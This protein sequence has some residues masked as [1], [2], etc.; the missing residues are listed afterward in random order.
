M[1]CPPSSATKT[2]PCVSSSI[3]VVKQARKTNIGGD[4]DIGIDPPRHWWCPRKKSD[5]D[6]HGALSNSSGANPPQ[7]RHSCTCSDRNDTMSLGHDNVPATIHEGLGSQNPRRYA[8][9]RS[10]SL[11]LS[12]TPALGTEF[13]G[14]DS[15]PTILRE[16]QHRAWRVSRRSPESKVSDGVIALPYRKEEEVDWSLIK[17]VRVEGGWVTV[18]DE[19]VE[20]QPQILTETTIQL[21]GE[22]HDLSCLGF[23]SCSYKGRDPYVT[24]VPQS[25]TSAVLEMERSEIMAYVRGHSGRGMGSTGKSSMLWADAC[26]NSPRESYGTSRQADEDPASAQH[27]GAEVCPRFADKEQSIRRN[28]SGTVIV[29]RITGDANRPDRSRRA[30]SSQDGLGD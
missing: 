5:T 30:D 10:L 9:H 18:E 15:F 12:N 28:T 19:H 24:F 29:R 1:S 2:H 16:L 26:D 27:V 14:C 13:L 8:S 23:T 17:I 4:T 11:P 7:P 25:P 21:R 20:S 22:S 6:S 3:V